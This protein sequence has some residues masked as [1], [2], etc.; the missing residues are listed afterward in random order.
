MVQGKIQS[1]IDSQV[2]NQQ[3]ESRKFLSVFFRFVGS[4]PLQEL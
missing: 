1:F 2:I 4:I 3:N